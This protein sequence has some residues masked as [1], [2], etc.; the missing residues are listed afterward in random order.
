MVNMLEIED[1]ILFPQRPAC[2]F[3]I[4]SKGSS[5]EQE[6]NGE[7]EA[8]QDVSLLTQNACF[9]PMPRLMPMLVLY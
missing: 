1:T 3:P 9:V 5:T 8:K 7:N 6:I 4:A 2:D